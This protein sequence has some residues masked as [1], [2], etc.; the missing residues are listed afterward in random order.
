MTNRDNLRVIVY[1]GSFGCD[2]GC[3]GHYVQM[4]GEEEFKFDHPSYR[5]DRKD[6]VKKLVTDTFGAEHVTD[7]DWDNVIVEET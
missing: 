5:G 2:T 7:I 3:C 4:G 1:H 6:F